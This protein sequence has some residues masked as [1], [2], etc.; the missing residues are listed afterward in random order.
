[1][2]ALTVSDFRFQERVWNLHGV[3]TICPHCAN[4]CA[5]RLEHRSGVVKRFL[6]RHHPAINDYWLCDW[7]RFAFGWMN[8]AT[9]FE[10]TMRGEEVAWEEILTAM[11][12]QPLTAL[13]S[14]FN[15]LEE[16]DL[17]RALFPRT[18]VLPAR[19]EPV[20]IKSRA[21]WITANSLAPNAAGAKALGIPEYAGEKLEAVLLFHHP[22]VDLPALEFSKLFLDTRFDTPLNAK[23]EGILPG[24]LFPEKE[25]TYMTEHGWVQH[26]PAAFRPFGLAR[27]AH[28]YLVHF[29]RLNGRSA[30]YDAIE[31]A[32]G[33][34]PFAGHKGYRDLPFKVEP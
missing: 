29:A 9:V 6:P 24:A 16:L 31:E 25:G 17:I 22:L 14:P 33:H 3:P 13:A 32:F 26:A 5:I 30:G 21:G 18:F 34:L 11:E 23:A 12:A 15:T 2:G 1:V 10:P 8:G 20:K 7:G 27:S 19:R 28:D 4:G